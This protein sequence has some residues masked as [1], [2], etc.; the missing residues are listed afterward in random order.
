V[1]RLL[2][3]VVLA[4]VLVG[5]SSKWKMSE[6][7]VQKAKYAALTVEGEHPLDASSTDAI[8]EARSLA[9]TLQEHNVAHAL[10]VLQEDKAAPGVVDAAFK[11]AAVEARATATSDTNTAARSL[12]K[13]VRLGQDPRT[14]E[15][16]GAVE[17]EHQGCLSA[18]NAVLDTRTRDSLAACSGDKV[19]SLGRYLHD[20][21][22]AD[23][24]ELARVESEKLRIELEKNEKRKVGAAAEA[25]AAKALI[26]RIEH[27][28]QERNREWLE[29][30]RNV[31]RGEFERCRQYAGRPAYEW[32][33]DC[34][35]VRNKT[36]EEVLA[37]F[38]KDCLERAKG[39]PYLTCQ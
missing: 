22:A 21:D 28:A 2:S 1:N 13:Y 32:P 36:L 34:S 5:C 39:D 16:L 33:S 12:E 14:S 15:M 6:A 23:E 27:E 4:V 17:Q 9:V 24:K 30:T 11:A 35:Q 8:N 3:T 38:H 25:V 20:W 29:R 26:Q 31:L 7:F 37:N 10:L 19:I 18:I